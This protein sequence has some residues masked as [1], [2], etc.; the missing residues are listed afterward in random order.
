M[1]AA[2]R[3]LAAR[4]AARLAPPRPGTPLGRAWALGARRPRLTLAVGGCV[5]AALLA[6]LLPVREHSNA[7]LEARRGGLPPSAAVRAVDLSPFLDNERW[8][9][10][11]AAA[12][13]QQQARQAQLETAAAMPEPTPREELQ[14]IGFVGVAVNVD[15]RAVLLALPNGEVVRRL[16]GDALA[17]GRELVSI[18]EDALVLRRASGEQATLTLFPPARP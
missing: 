15:E 14:A 8:G 11:I 6:A 2:A 1:N 17:D 4:L 16:A 9:M 3:R 7:A 5:A 12:G 10:S 13:R 18:A